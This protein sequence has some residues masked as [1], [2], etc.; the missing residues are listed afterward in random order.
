M[1][2]FSNVY[3][4]YWLHRDQ[5]VHVEFWN[6][7]V[8]VIGIDDYGYLKVRRKNGK[9]HTLQ[10]DGNRFDMMRNLIVFK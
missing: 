2:E 4:K 6:E 5:S 1:K 9:I 3:E 8:Q 7:E 10:P